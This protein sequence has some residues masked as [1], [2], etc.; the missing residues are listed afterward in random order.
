MKLQEVQL[1]D[2]VPTGQPGDYTSRLSSVDSPQAASGWSLDYEAGMVTAVKGDQSL[3]IPMA[4]VA[5]MRPEPKAA[6]PVKA[7]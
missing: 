4:N 3:L 2:K 7:A 5:Y 1:R 6:K